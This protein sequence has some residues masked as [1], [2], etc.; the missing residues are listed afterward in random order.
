MTAYLIFC[1]LYEG[2]Y[3]RI[4]NEK[5]LLKHYK[6]IEKAKPYI[7][8]IENVLEQYIVYDEPEFD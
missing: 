6:P 2:I 3:Y 8:I 7:P 4:A 5:T 1:L